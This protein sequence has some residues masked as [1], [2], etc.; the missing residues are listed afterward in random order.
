MRGGAIAPRE[1]SS[2]R[3]IRVEGGCGEGGEGTGAGVGDEGALPTPVG[4]VERDRTS[5]SESV[6]GSENSRTSASTQSW[7]RRRMWSRRVCVR[8]FGGGVIDNCRPQVGKNIL[9]KRRGLKSMTLICV[10]DRRRSPCLRTRGDMRRRARAAMMRR[11][12][13]DGERV[14]PHPGMPK[15]T[16]TVARLA[17]RDAWVE[18]EGSGEE[19]GLVLGTWRGRLGGSVEARLLVGSN[20]GVTALRAYAAGECVTVWHGRVYSGGGTSACPALAMVRE[21]VVDGSDGKGGAQ[22]VREAT[23]APNV[24]LALLGCTVCDTPYI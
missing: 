12:E 20:G 14:H 11:H 3:G 23:G 10:P 6:C 17:S 5:E 15:G 7:K 1:G 18:W 2:R 8:N 22:H 24:A 19:R 16:A 4:N 9:M 13:E 21:V